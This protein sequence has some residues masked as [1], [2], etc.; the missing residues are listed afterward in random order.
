MKLRGFRIELGEI[1]AV[2]T[3]HPEVA[4]AAVTLREDNA[5]T[6]Q[7]VAYVVQSTGSRM[8][9]EEAWERG[10]GGAGKRE[11][12]DSPHLPI[13]PSPHF[14]SNLR[15]DLA[16][17]LPTYM[18]PTQFVALDTLPLLPNGK[19]NRRALPAPDRP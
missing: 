3:Q 5:Q 10:V 18:V 11:N 12:L 6:A 14:P 17:H 1:E 16:N 7:L 4:Q 15:T 19:V 8:K 9:D 13:S 2:L